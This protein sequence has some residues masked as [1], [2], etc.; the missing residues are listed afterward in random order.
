MVLRIKT[1]RSA[2]S[3]IRV[4]N[5]NGFVA[6]NFRGTNP[7]LRTSDARFALTLRLTR[8]AL[9]GPAPDQASA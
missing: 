2:D 3:I 4:R 5:C 6:S 7:V 1:A 8:S 9:A